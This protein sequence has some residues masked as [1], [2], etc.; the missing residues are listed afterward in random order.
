MAITMDPRTR[1]V[2]INGTPAPVKYGG[3]VDKS[4]MWAALRR[5]EQNDE[6]E[7]E[8]GPPNVELTVHGSKLRAEIELLDIEQFTG[9]LPD[10]DAVIPL[11]QT[12]GGHYPVASLG[13]T[14]VND[15][16]DGPAMERIV[17]VNG[18]NKYKLTISCILLNPDVKQGRRAKS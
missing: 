2:N 15:A 6:P 7:V 8:K 12:K 1:T 4:P 3:T 13:W 16:V 14:V 10:S 9:F 18:G 5:E 11:R 17:E